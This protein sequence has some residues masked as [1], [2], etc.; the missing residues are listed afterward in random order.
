M[1]FVTVDGDDEQGRLRVME[2]GKSSLLMIPAERLRQEVLFCLRQIQVFAPTVV[3]VR[4]RFRV[5]VDGAFS[6][7]E[8]VTREVP[9]D[10]IRREQALRAIL[11]CNVLLLL[12]HLVAYSGVLLTYIPISS[13][14]LDHLVVSPVHLDQQLEELVSGAGTEVDFSRVCGVVERAESV[15]VRDVQDMHWCF[16]WMTVFTQRELSCHVLLHELV[17]HSVVS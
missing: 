10:A 7:L 17:G 13:P 11:R 6:G 8:L 12:T 2:Y 5:G 15:R 4:V 14:L 16:R 9:A 3:V 1:A